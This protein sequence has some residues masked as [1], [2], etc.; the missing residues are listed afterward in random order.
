MFAVKTDHIFA[1]WQ[2]ILLPSQRKHRSPTDCLDSGVILL[3]KGECF[4]KYYGV[5]RVAYGR[6]VPSN[7]HPSTFLSPTVLQYSDTVPIPI[8]HVLSDIR[9][10]AS[11][12]KT[13]AFTRQPTS[14]IQ[15]HSSISSVSILNHFQ[16]ALVR[17][18]TPP[19]AILATSILYECNTSSP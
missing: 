18:H 15:I 14:P 12:V 6:G 5:R 9:S 11:G 2:T 10:Q 1:D 19:A 3:R 13:C 7:Y 16:H 8:C 4:K 17:F